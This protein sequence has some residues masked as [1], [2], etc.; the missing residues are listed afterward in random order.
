MECLVLGFGRIG[1]LLAYRL[2][3]LGAH[4]TVTARK[5]AD[6]AWIRAYGWQALDTGRLDGALCDFGAVFNTV[7]S[8]VLGH[9]LLAQLPKGCL[10]VELASVQGIDLA[11]AEELDCPRMGPLLPGRMVPAAAAVAIRDAVDYI[12]KERGDPV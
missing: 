12:L 1:K 9:L 4:V 5:P 8:P 2:H 7:P 6:L 11:A 10:C 3:G